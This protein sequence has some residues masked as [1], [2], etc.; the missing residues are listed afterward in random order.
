MQL[1]LGGLITLSVTAIVQILIIPWVQRRARIRERW[2]QDMLELS[3]LL[4]D[5]MTSRVNDLLVF[6]SNYVEVNGISAP[7]DE[8][9]YLELARARKAVTR[10]WDKTHALFLR[11]RRLSLKV[12]RMHPRAEVW[13][14]LD[15]HLSGM[16]RALH[17]LDLQIFPTI[18]E[19]TLTQ[20][21]ENL[22]TNHLMARLIVD[23]TNANMKPPRETI[24]D[25][26]RHRQI[27]RSLHSQN[28]GKVDGTDGRGSETP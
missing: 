9:H 16:N 19:A 13:S 22:S 12:A 2:E 20:N 10:T 21:S 3:T 5:E 1:V 24:K 18:K 4:K 23:R 17:G 8:A 7:H 6:L 26:R 14:A 11:I 25:R 27:V 15:S 28:V